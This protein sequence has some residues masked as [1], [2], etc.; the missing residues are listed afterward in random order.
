MIISLQPRHKIIGKDFL[1]FIKRILHVKYLPQWN[2]D[3]IPFKHHRM[4]YYQ[5]IV[6]DM[7]VIQQKNVYIN[8]P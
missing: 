8:N 5:V 1:Y 4:W 7:H 2:H 3:K 6:I